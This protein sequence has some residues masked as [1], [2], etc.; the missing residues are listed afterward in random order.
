MTKRTG[1]R[2][3]L[4]VGALVVLAGCAAGPNAAVGSGGA[5]AGFWFGLWH[6]LISPITTVVSLFTDEVSI[7]EVRNSGNWY[8]V[9]FIF[10]VSVAF[11]GAARS[12]A[13]A[14]GRRGRRPARQR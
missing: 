3:A 6:G 8:D 11:S 4:L 9:G 7:Y 14:S 13:G 10:G 2:T 12:G 5:Q 1:L